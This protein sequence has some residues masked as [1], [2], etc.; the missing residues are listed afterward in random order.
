MLSSDRLFP[1][2]PQC[3]LT[4]CPLWSAVR[5]SSVLLLL[6]VGTLVCCRLYARYSGG[7]G[8]GGAGGG[9]GDS[10]WRRL[11]RTLLGTD[12]SAPPTIIEDEDDLTPDD[13][14]QVSPA[15]P[16]TPVVTGR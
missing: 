9:D 3:C 13:D 2:V 11:L 14:I 16:P 8:A 10:G 1:V 12:W 15:P 6:G 5:T 4:V 7:S